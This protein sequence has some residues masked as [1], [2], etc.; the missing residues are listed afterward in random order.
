[1][2]T[3]DSQAG[4]GSHHHGEDLVL[5]VLPS[6]SLGADPSWAAAAG[7]GAAPPATRVMSPSYALEVS[8]T[9]RNLNEGIIQGMHVQ[10]QV[11]KNGMFE[12]AVCTMCGKYGHPICLGLENFLGYPFCADCLPPAISQ[13]NAAQDAMH[14]EQWRRDLAQQMARWKPE[15][16]PQ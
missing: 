15:R 3:P 2:T 12:P 1:M 6:T 13:Y 16:C 11:C 7:A 9:H 4:G 8:P 10:C 14:R 5:A